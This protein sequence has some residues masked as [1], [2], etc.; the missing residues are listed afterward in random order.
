MLVS[1]LALFPA[2]VHHPVL[3]T[4]TKNKRVFTNI[5]RGTKGKG[6]VCEHRQREGG[7]KNDYEAFY[8]ALPAVLGL[9]SRR[10]K[11]AQLAQD[12]EHMHKMLCFL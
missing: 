2:H 7:A 12:K 8:V 6:L 1:L 9:E 3:I 10:V 11:N 4:Q 5:G